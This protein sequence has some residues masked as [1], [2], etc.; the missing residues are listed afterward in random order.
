MVGAKHFIRK[1]QIQFLHA[2][3]YLFFIALRN[4]SYIESGKQKNA[5][6]NQVVACLLQYESMG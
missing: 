2:E 1:I 3:G 6:F 5:L 4:K